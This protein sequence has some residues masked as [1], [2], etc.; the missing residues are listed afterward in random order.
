[1]E[2]GSHILTATADGYGLDLR[3]LDTRDK[4]DNLD[5]H[6]V[7]DDVPIEGRILDLEGRPVIGA[8]IRIFRLSALAD[9]NLDLFLKRWKSGPVEALSG[10]AGVRRE[11]KGAGWRKARLSIGGNYPGNP[12]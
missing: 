6:L 11:P 2:S 10:D 12:A 9:E 4:D 7:K 5:L 3:Q 8:T 1:M